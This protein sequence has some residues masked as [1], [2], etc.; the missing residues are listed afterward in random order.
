MAAG[1]RQDRDAGR[2]GLAQPGA[3]VIPEGDEADDRHG[4]RPEQVRQRVGEVAGD[5]AGPGGLAQ[6]GGLGADPGDAVQHELGEEGVEVGEVPVQDALGAAC[7]GGDRPAGQRVRPVPEQDALGGVEQLLARVADGD[8][9]RHRRIP[10][11]LHRSAYL[12]DEWAR[13]H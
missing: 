11:S 4:D 7:L 9:G 13:A 1:L 10:P 6:G 3:Q 12:I 5:G 2:P 8:P